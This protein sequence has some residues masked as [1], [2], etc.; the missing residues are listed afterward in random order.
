M[1]AH[2]VE[3]RIVRESDSSKFI[4]IG[5]DWCEVYNSGSNE[6]KLYIQIS[7]ETIVNIKDWGKHALAGVEVRNCDT[8]PTTPDEIK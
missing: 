8:Y 4:G 1:K 7:P 5:Y 2:R 6:V 3:Y